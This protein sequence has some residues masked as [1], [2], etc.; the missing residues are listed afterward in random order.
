MNN[1][2]FMLKT[3]SG[4]EKNEREALGLYERIMASERN[5]PGAKAIKNIASKNIE[6]IKGCLALPNGCESLPANERGAR[7][8]SD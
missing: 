3:G 5:D 6:S 7:R 8:S 2:A 4:T 1:L